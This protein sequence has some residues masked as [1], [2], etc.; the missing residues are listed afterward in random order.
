[1]SQITFDTI[2]NEVDTNAGIQ[3]VACH[4]C[5]KDNLFPIMDAGV[6]YEDWFTCTSCGCLDHV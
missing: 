1:M 4:A 2:L 6:L 5:G 3:R